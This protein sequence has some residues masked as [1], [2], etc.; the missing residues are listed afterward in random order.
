MP[1]RALRTAASG[2]YAQQLNIEV[3]ANNIANVNTT[4]FKKNK[5]E[6][7]DLMYQE[8]IVNPLS[9]S[10]PGST[11]ASV[12]KIQIGNG[13]QPSSTQKIYRQGDVVETRNQLDIAIQGEGFLQIQKPDGSFVY[14]RDGSLKVNSEGKLI[15]ASGYKIDP[16]V[17]LD[18]NTMGVIISRDG[19]IEIEELKGDKVSVGQVELVRFMN[20]AGLKALGDNLYAETEAS[21][22]PILGTAGSDGFGEVVQGF[23]E[24]SNV[25]IVEEMIAMITAQR[26]YEMNSK[27]V[28]T[29]EEMMSMANNLK[30]G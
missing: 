22:K 1:T 13:V 20:P 12:N 18:E 10:T 9:S 6:F 2:M 11:D 26:A 7:Q 25:D 28:K 24:A 30:R 3:I 17:S 4:G 8:V 29:V 14:T 16:E 19:Y 23:L 27:T 5:A 15:T 21:G